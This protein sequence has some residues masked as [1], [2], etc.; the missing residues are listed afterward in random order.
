MF[1]GHINS[2]DMI[3]QYQGINKF[4]TNTCGDKDAFKRSLSPSIFLSAHILSHSQELGKCLA[5]SHYFLLNEK[6]DKVTSDL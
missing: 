5:I 3:P 2:L 4:S 6:F 1:F